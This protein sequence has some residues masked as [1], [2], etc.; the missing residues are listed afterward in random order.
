VKNID[1][2]QQLDPALFEA[3]FE[4]S[5]IRQSRLNIAGK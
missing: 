4:Y 3:L 5:Y 1:D 2:A